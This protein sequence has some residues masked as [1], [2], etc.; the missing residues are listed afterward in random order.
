MSRQRVA[1]LGSGSWGSTLALLAAH[2]HA[3]VRLWTRDESQRDAV[4]RHHRTG[5]EAAALRLSSSVDATTD[6]GDALAF[7]ELVVVVVPSAAVREVMRAAAPHL[8]PSHRLVIAT[9]GLEAETHRRMS[10]VVQEESCVRQLAVLAGPNIAPEIRRGLPAASVV[11]TR[12]PMLEAE[13]RRLLETSRFRLFRSTDVLGVELAAALKNVV[14]IAAGVVDAL[15]LGE[16]AKAF[17]VA[18]GLA[19]MTRL[20]IEAGAERATFTGLAGVGDLVVTCASRDSRN[21]RLGEALA[22]RV[23]LPNALQQIGM[24]VEGVAAASAARRWAKEAGLELPL[25]E[26]VAAALFDGLPP[27]RG[28]ERLLRLPTTMPVPEP[29]HGG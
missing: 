3:R 29:A 15:E 13:L 5:S 6:L 24:V 21:H 9:K 19:E 23:P 4:N 2:D 17:L 22:N 7:S 20:G 10:E 1:I 11:A 26:Q 18:R 16:N 14:A 25:F 28:L 12:F 8:R 27:R